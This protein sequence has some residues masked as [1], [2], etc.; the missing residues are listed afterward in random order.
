[1]DVRTDSFDVHEILL[2]LEQKSSE[3]SK[4]AAKPLP[5]ERL[6]AGTA[7]KSQAALFRLPFDILDEIFNYVP[8][9]SLPAFALASRD[10]CR[11]ARSR[12]FTNVV[13]DY[14]P[15]SW[16]LAHRLLSEASLGRE[17]ATRRAPLPPI[18]P[19]V[20]QITICTAKEYI[21]QYHST[22]I[23]EPRSISTEKLREIME[24][25]TRYVRTVQLV[26]AN[27]LPN[28][29]T[30]IWT[31]RVLF[32]EETHLA[33]CGSPAQNLILADVAGD[34]RFC[35]DNC[36]T[37]WPLRTLHIGIANVPN[38][39]LSCRTVGLANGLLR[40][41]AS[42]LESLT[43]IQGHEA[44]YLKHSFSDSAA[45][46]PKFS[47]LRI[48]Q[49]SGLRFSD[50]SVLESLI[51]PSGRLQKLGIQHAHVGDYFSKCG[52]L[53]SLESLTWLPQ[54]NEPD[55]QLIYFLRSNPQ[56]KELYLRKAYTS[57]FIDTS[58]LPLLG[59]SFDRLTS[60]SL[61]G[62]E[63]AIEETSLELIG[64]IHTLQ[65]LH[66]TA[67]DQMYSFQWVVDH[68]AIR[69]HLSQLVNLKTLLL[70]R[71]VRTIS[72]GP[73]S[74]HNDDS[75]SDPDDASDDTSSMTLEDNPN[76]DLDAIIAAVTL[77]VYAAPTYD[78]QDETEIQTD[79]LNR[80]YS[81]QDDRS[82]D[83]DIEDEDGD[84]NWNQNAMI[85]RPFSVPSSGRY[86]NSSLSSLLHRMQDEKVE[87]EAQKYFTAFGKLEM[88]HMGR[89][90]FD[91]GFDEATG[92]LWCNKRWAHPEDLLSS[93]LGR[94]LMFGDDG[95]DRA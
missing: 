31:D 61:V 36:T 73:P 93:V 55:D 39:R 76:T 65:L 68:D 58:L 82:N 60:L 59:S 19:V 5:F 51:S 53:N 77:G 35:L 24:R 11:L 14:S 27:S 52:T 83:G 89:Q 67:G 37:N 79:E 23:W 38:Y 3:P 41:S 33:L 15:N 74:Q 94:E 62:K 84:Y 88:L 12:Q 45:P 7:P 2:L 1:M 47:A 69:R 95:F 54:H 87:Q 56:L 32:N 43:W 4:T 29:E 66:L 71:D 44:K 85:R 16:A 17:G 13:L 86:G 28:V 81:D 78:T 22:S 26:L 40:M 70:S 90:E 49:I 46:C 48:L 91:R 42:H 80:E 18:G 72:S 25:Y 20:R 57:D 10:C 34:G 50:D 21:Q 9:R 64:K 30:I 92:L 75:S 8:Y 6:V 63:K